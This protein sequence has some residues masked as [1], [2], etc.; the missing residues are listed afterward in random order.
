M[1]CDLKIPDLRSDVV[2]WYE[3]PVEPGDDASEDE[4][5][6][7]RGEDEEEQ[8]VRSSPSHAS[9]FIQALQGLG[10]P[11]NADQVPD[12]LYC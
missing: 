9:N 7:D 8:A 4:V 5:E 11:F 6:E 2:E 3:P 10:E 12:F 1:F